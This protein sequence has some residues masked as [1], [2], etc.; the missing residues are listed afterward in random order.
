NT[1][2]AQLYYEE[3]AREKSFPQEISPSRPSIDERVNKTF[4]AVNER[5]KNEVMW[6]TVFDRMSANRHVP[7]YGIRTVSHQTREEK[8]YINKNFF[9]RPEPY[10]I[11]DSVMLTRL[12]RD[13][14][15]NFYGS[16]ET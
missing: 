9:G 16:R 13:Q 10:K 5:I 6:E 15:K 4:A 7:E 2:R 12:R 8:E 11:D 3:K 14:A 1:G